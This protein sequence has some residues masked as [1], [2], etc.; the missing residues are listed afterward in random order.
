MSSSLSIAAGGMQAAGRRFETAA[1]SIVSSGA[2]LQS[3]PARPAQRPAATQ[4]GSPPPIRQV[5]D[6]PGLTEGLIDLKLAET[7][8]K[9]Q[10]EVLKAASRLEQE[11][12]NLIA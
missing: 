2:A 6:T 4:T 7:S 11:T 5:F 10:I 12:L 1:R 9:A 8:Y 3:E